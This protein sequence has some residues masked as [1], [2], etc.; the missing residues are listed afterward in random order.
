MQGERIRFLEGLVNKNENELARLREF[1]ALQEK[2]EAARRLKN[3]DLIGD[4]ETL[5]E[6]LL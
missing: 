2:V 1:V 6:R 5:V 3:N 4:I